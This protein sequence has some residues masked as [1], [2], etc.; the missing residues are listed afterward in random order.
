MMLAKVSP[1]PTS[2]VAWI[3]GGPLAASYNGTRT[4]KLRAPQHGARHPSV[5]LTGRP[6]ARSSPAC[7]ASG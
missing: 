5:G 7:T 6:A 2:D 1:P 4:R 3:D